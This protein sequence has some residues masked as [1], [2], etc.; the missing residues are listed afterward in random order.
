MK[1]Q[2]LVNKSK[3]LAQTEKYVEAAEYYEKALELDPN[4]PVAL[5]KALIVE[6]FGNLQEAL[7]IHDK[8]FDIDSTYSLSIYNKG[9][10]CEKLERYDQAIK[11][12]DKVIDLDKS[13]LMPGLVSL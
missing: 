8:V 5:N 7:K 3:L 4:N 11:C 12:Y 9:R 13:I 2:A 10:L 6:M 1:Q